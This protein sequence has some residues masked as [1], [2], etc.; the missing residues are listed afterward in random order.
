[1]RLLQFQ[2]DHRCT[3][4]F[5]LEPAPDFSF[6]DVCDADAAQSHSKIIIST[7]HPKT[8]PLQN[9]FSSIFHPFVPAFPLISIQ[10][11]NFSISQFSSG[12]D[13]GEHGTCQ[14][15]WQGGFPGRSPPPQRHHHALAAWP[16]GGGTLRDLG[17]R[18]VHVAA[19]VDLGAGVVYPGGNRVETWGKVGHLGKSWDFGLK[20]TKF[21]KYHLNM[22]IFFRDSG[23]VWACALRNCLEV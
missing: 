18:R 14:H 13:F 7:A 1:M 4:S 8:S 17:V 12:L 2:D 10:F 19:M 15:Q 23:M 21:T 3:S 20:L 22:M 16:G 11:L 5:C 6:R 9:H